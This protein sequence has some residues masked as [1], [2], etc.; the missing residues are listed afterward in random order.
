MSTRIELRNQKRKDVVEA[1]VI[2]QEPVHLVR[3]IYNLPERTVFDW[4]S[5][6]RAGGWDAL[7]EGKRSGR[8]RKLSAE[9]MQWVYKAVTMGNP[10]HYQFDFCLWTLGVLGTLIKQARGVKLS[11]SAVSR[12]LR[13]L[14]LSAQRPVYKLYKQ[15]PKQVKRYLSKT[16]PE[17][18]AQAKAMGA[19]LF[20]VDEASVRSDAHRG[21]TW[22]KRGETPVIRDSGGR[23]GLN[24]ISAISPRGEMRF[25]F[26]AG[27]MNSSRFIQFLKKLRKDAGKPILVIV[28]NAKYHYS[29]E[30]RRF[31]K[32]QDGQILLAFLP[33]YSP[34]LNPDEQVWN[35]AKHQLSQRPVWDKHDMKRHLSAILH[36]LQKRTGLIMSFF[37]MKDTKYIL[38]VFI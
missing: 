18:V 28:D 33:A 22:G 11:K 27:G 24:M 30:T 15:D 29:K 34:E 2:R 12:L 5:R 26:I 10:M 16:F 17:A 35:H 38:E 36:S 13:H 14:G 8:P 37:K 20:F 19:Q 23:F 6:Y 25:S 9:D 32:Q 31:L 7:K 3:R 4:L 21:A 1:I